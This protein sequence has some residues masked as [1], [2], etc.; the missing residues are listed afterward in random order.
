MSDVRV[1]GTF[2]T[3]EVP[4]KPPISIMLESVRWHQLRD[5]VLAITL[6]VFKAVEAPFLRVRVTAPVAPVQVRLKAWPA[7]MELKDGL[8]N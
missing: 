3:Y 1:D 2:Q 7:V 8:V 6:T 4:V 5:T